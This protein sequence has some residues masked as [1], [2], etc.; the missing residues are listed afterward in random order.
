M[1]IKVCGMREPGN[2]AAVASLCPDM[3]GFIFYPLSPRYAGNLLPEAVHV[4]P[5][6][7]QRTG[8]FVNEEE[9]V[10]L[11]IA[12]RYRIDTIQLHGAE[13]PEFCRKFR[14]KG[15]RVVKAVGIGGTEDLE[16]CGKYEGGCDMLLFDTKS[17]KHGWNGAGF[18]LGTFRK[19]QGRTAF[20]A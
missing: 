14:D 1:L 8:V 4:L 2:I 18:R 19:L 16:A 3:L 12:E 15:F 9:A 7:I 20:P 17:P 11:G 13:S 10:I 6:D 5:P